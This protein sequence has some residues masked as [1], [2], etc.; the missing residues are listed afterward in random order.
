MKKIITK[1]ITLL[2][3]VTVFWNNQIVNAHPGN[4]DSN[5]GH[6]CRTNCPSWGYDYGEYHTH[7]SFDSSSY[8]STS[9]DFIWLVII[10]GLLFII[11]LIYNN[12]SDLK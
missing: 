10:G 11:Y 6:Y 1:V 4:T 12:K 7:S 5:G 2:L 8:N 9:N 3:S